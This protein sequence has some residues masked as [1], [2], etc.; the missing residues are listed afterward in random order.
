MF[1][2]RQTRK[3]QSRGW[4]RKSRRDFSEGQ[5]SFQALRFRIPARSWHVG[6]TESFEKRSGWSNPWWG[7]ECNE[8]P[9]V[10]TRHQYEALLSV[11]NFCICRRGMYMYVYIYLCLYLYSMYM[12]VYVCIRIRKK[13]ENTIQLFMKINH[14]ISKHL[15]FKGKQY[16]NILIKM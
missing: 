15:K 4:N 6:S 10:E 14:F 5:S 16:R 3:L 2:L 9:H 13:G 7:R 8:I 1:V 11:I 12:S